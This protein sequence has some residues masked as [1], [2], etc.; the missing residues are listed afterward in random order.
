MINIKILNLLLKQKTT[1]L[2]FAWNSKN[3]EIIKNIL[4]YKN[5][6]LAKILML[7][8]YFLSSGFIKLARLSLHLGD[9]VVGHISK[10]RG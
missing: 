10:I 7:F 1:M 2:M 9:Q 8:I 5:Y 4:I 3:I 6:G